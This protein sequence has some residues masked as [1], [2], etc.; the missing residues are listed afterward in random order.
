MRLTNK[1]TEEV[2][3]LSHKWYNFEPT[4]SEIEEY[5]EATVHGTKDIGGKF[6]KNLLMQA[7]TA[8]DRTIK[9]W[10]EDL[11]NGLL[12]V[13]ELYE[14]FGDSA[15]GKKLIDAIGNGM[16]YSKPR[17]GSGYAAITGYNIIQ[18]CSTKS[19]STTG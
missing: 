9:V 15:Y 6:S 5:I 3:F 8:M 13:A 10:R 1:Q 7:K 11:L 17:N 2:W 12:S 14:D 16:D 4:D 19:Q 18:Q